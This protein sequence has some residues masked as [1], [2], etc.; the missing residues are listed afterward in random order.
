MQ[1]DTAN[2]KINQLEIRELQAA[3]PNS[4]VRFKSQCDNTE[5]RISETSSDKRKLLENTEANIKFSVLSLHF[6]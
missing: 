3:V 2:L 5:E 1:I 4:L 6:Q